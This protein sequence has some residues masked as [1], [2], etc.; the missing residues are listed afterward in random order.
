VSDEGANRFGLT[1]NKWDSLCERITK[2]ACVPVIGGELRRGIM[3]LSDELAHAWATQLNYPLQRDTEL[4]IVAEYARTQAADENQLL[5]D[6]AAFAKSKSVVSDDA[7]DDG[8][9]LRVLAE[10]PFKIYITTAFDDLMATA[11]RRFRPNSNPVTV[12]CAWSPTERDWDRS[13]EPEI[14]EPTLEA[15][16][17]F[18]L[19]GRWDDPASMVL[20]ESDHID[21][22]LRIVGDSRQTAEKVMML[23]PHIKNAMAS[24]SW[25]F[26]GYG[27]ADR[28]LRGLL[29]ALGS[30]IDSKRQAVAVQLQHDQ[31][32]AEREAEAD[33][34]LTRY[35]GRLLGRQVDVVLQDAKPF[36]RAIKD[37]VEKRKAAP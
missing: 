19:H 11:L 10:L 31:A 17:V 35:F 34:F 33:D 16:I 14:P 24:N 26:L 15:P 25:F 20:T 1:E 23:P 12:S 3:P 27:A 7:M 5:D 37:E 18:H 32:V 13:N 28:N 22:T 30:Q 9:P 29:R 6:F 4:A 2:G 8:H 36:L 21:F